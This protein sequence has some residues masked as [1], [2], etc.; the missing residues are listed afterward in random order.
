[1]NFIFFAGESPL[2]EEKKFK[3][4]KCKKPLPLPCL[5]LPNAPRSLAAQHPGELRASEQGGN[6]RAGAGPRKVDR[7]ARKEQALGGA[8]PRG[9][10]AIP[11]PGGLDCARSCLVLRLGLRIF[12]MAE[13]N[14][15]PRYPPAS[16]PSPSLCLG[17]SVLATRALPLC[18]IAGHVLFSGL[19]R[20]A[21]SLLAQPLHRRL[22]INVTSPTWHF[23]TNSFKIASHP[24]RLFPSSYSAFFISL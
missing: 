2:H 4:K 20:P 24:T 11:T 10:G 18:G 3:K 1:M 12:T 14:P 15:T 9:K 13:L 6:R 17:P 16:P 23:W 22:C 8:G 7:S 21:L 5:S 19:L